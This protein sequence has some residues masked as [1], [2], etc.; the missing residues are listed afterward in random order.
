MESIEKRPRIELTPEQKKRIEEN[1]QKALA[2]RERLLKQNRDASSH[3]QEIIPV[4]KA[5][6]KQEEIK[7]KKNEELKPLNR[8]KDYIDYDFSTMKD[9][10]GGF[11]DDPP[12]IDEN[13]NRALEE[14]KEKQKE[15]I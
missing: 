9:T 5:I 3:K 15:N 12:D 11:M 1:R 7:H 14:W 4:P 13:E 2:I 10:H 8:K 6:E